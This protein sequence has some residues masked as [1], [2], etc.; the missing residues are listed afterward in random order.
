MALREIRKVE[1]VLQNG[2]DARKMWSLKKI[3][4]GVIRNLSKVVL[5]LYTSRDM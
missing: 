3:K 4:K 2:R 5:Y 1:R